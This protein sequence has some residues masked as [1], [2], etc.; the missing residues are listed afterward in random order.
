MISKFNKRISFLLCVIDTFNKYAWA[1][2]L[3]DKRD[4]TIS[5]AFQ[6]LLHEF[7]RKPNKPNIDKNSEFYNRPMSFAIDQWNH[8]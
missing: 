3:K 6:K 1:I 8:G 7:N 4:I 2:S 5:N